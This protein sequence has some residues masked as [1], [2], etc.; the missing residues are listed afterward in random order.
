MYFPI[1]FHKPKCMIYIILC[2]TFPLINWKFVRPKIKSEFFISIVFQLFL[3][4]IFITFAIFIYLYQ[5]K[6]YE[7]TQYQ[8]NEDNEII[9]LKYYKI[10]PIIICGVFS[11]I[12]SD[13]S[14]YDIFYSYQMKKMNL[15]L[16]A[17]FEMI[18]L[19]IS[20]VFN[21]K[22]FLNS[23]QY[24]HHYIS[25]G[26]IILFLIIIIIIESLNTINI[27]FISFIFVILISL[28]SMY[29]YSV[30]YVIVKILN[31]QYFM[32]ISLLLF[33]LGIFGILILLIFD[34]FYVFIFNYDSK[35]IFKIGK[36]NSETLIKD[37]IFLIIYRIN[38]FFNLFFNFK[39]IEELNPSYTLISYGL[40]NI[41]QVII[42]KELEL[43]IK[44]ILY[45][46]SLFL[47]CIYLEIITFNFCKLDK[48]TQ[49]EISKRA[50]NSTNELIITSEESLY[51]TN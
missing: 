23:K 25:I 26:L 46:L 22:Y 29:L 49:Y 32:N 2:F 12:L 4:H 24:I 14:Y 18:S 19:F 21:E 9:D 34:F 15:E 5:K 43:N 17:N 30:I 44:N 40:Y 35:F 36:I 8:S 45:I 51:S 33:I 20:H 6:M 47:F 31:Y 42:N 41:I 16:I 39:I 7:K 48:N 11:Y 13:V 27:N 1:K 28:E 10:L 50:E 37:I 3:K 38:S